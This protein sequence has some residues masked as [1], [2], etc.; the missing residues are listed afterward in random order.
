M[1]AR[2]VVREAGGVHQGGR[3]ETLPSLVA[4]VGAERVQPGEADP[5]DYARAIADGALLALI[6][7]LGLLQ[8]GHET[9][10][11]L[12]QLASVSLYL[13]AL[14]ASP[15]RSWTPKLAALFALPARA[16]SGAPAVALALGLVGIAALL[17]SAVSL[18]VIV[19]AVTR[20]QESI[21]I[22]EVFA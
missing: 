2:A 11:E 21:G 19:D 18:W 14:C 20:R 1:P 13:Y 6:A 12:A 17:A 7:T 4:A 10:P 9:T 22:G 8:L 15:F 3:G 16:A 5:V